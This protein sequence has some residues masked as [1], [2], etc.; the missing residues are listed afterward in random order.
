VHLLDAGAT[1][2]G[3]QGHLGLRNIR[4]TGVYARFTERR[5]G[6]LLRSLGRS[7]KIVR[8]AAR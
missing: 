4:S 6:S 2:E 3:V 7:T 1:L 5:P 8:P